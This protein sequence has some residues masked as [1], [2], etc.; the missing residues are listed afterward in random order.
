[1][2]AK[3]KTRLKYQIVG[4]AL[5]VLAVLFAGLLLIP[6]NVS[7]SEQEYSEIAVPYIGSPQTKPE[8]MKFTQCKDILE[9]D[10]KKLKYGFPLTT[11]LRYQYYRVAAR[12]KE[13]QQ[14][15]YMAR[16]IADISI[17]TLLLAYGV[18][19]IYRSKKITR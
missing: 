6:I 1:M 12:Q 9:T 3:L 13:V 14:S 5:V 19:L 10:F 15:Y 16:L 7:L 18:G 4:A 17:S 11:K 2:K 8:C